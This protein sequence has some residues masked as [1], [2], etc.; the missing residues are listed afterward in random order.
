MHAKQLIAL[1]L[2]LVLLGCSKLTLDNYN[3]I[4][5]GMTY[6]EVVQLIGKPAKCDDL[7]GLRSCTWGDEARSVNVSFVDNKVLLF[8]SKNMK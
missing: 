3:R 8:A 1:G 5:V 4:S 7:M 2:F 6:D